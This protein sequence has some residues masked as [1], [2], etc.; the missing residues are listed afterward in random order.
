MLSRAVKFLIQ[1][2]ALAV[3][4]AVLAWLLPAFTIRN[5]WSA[6]A[7]TI[8]LLLLTTF[9]R[10]LLVRLTMPL[11][12]VTMGAFSLVISIVIIWLTAWILP[13]IEIH[14]ILAPLVIVVVLTL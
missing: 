1:F 7:G 12:A 9:L 3:T 5:F 2:L 8:V 6:I 4:L 13:G 11:N 10:P 14:G